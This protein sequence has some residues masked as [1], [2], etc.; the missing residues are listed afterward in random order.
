MHVRDQLADNLVEGFSS[1]L[2]LFLPF[3]IVNN[4]LKKAYGLII[5]RD[6]FLK[7]GTPV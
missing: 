6:C 2:Y 1:V 4:A 7:I 3:T 5:F